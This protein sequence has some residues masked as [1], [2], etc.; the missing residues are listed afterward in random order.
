MLT[1]IQCKSAKPKEKSYKLSDSGG[2]YLEVPPKGNKRWRLKYYFLGKEKRISLG[3]YPIVSLADAREARDEAKRLL[4]QDID[5]SEARQKKKRKMKRSHANTFKAIALEWFELKSHEWSNNYQRKIKLGLEKNVFP[6]IGHRPINEIEPP[7][8]LDEC[9]R[10]IERRGSYDIASRTSQICGQIFRYGIQTGRCKWD[11]SK[12]LRGALKSKKTE[13]FRTIDLKDLPS[14]IKAL[15]ENKARLYESTRNAVWLSMHIFLRPKEIRTLKWSYVDFDNALITIPAE[16]M[17]MKR[18]LLVPLS[19]QV[20]RILKAQ[21][22]AVSPLSTEYVFPGHYKH[23]KPMSDATVGKA[24]KALGFGDK[25]V[26][27]GFRAL[28]RTA[29]R[30]KLGYE[31]EVIEKQLA[32]ESKGALREAYDRTQFIDQRTQMMSEWSDL[33]DQLSL[34]KGE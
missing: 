4:S 26:A 20:I 19:K 24:I 3:I 7:E 18:D 28:A 11:I 32:H 5:P 15:K 1:N 14:F 25:L 31:V 33:I 29:I 10:R 2:L 30:E 21:E 17:K 12:D 13:H 8:L 27:H 23:K 9:L 6:Y 34:E 16:V 22:T